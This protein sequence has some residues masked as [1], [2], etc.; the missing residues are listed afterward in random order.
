MIFNQSI[1]TK[2]RMNENI[3]CTVSQNLIDYSI[4]PS[5]LSKLDQLNSD[6]LRQILPFLTRI[7][8]RSVDTDESFEQLKIIIL[9]KL[10]LFEDTNQIKAYLNVDFNQIYE[11][12]IKH[13]ATRKKSQTLSV[14]SCGI[15]F[16]NTKFIYNLKINFIKYRRIRKCKSNFKIVNDIKHSFIWKY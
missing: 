11:D 15:Q 16:F 12:V 14:Y 8:M 2:K 9:E 7:W 10:S 5:D 1:N 6:E 3:A 13:L 4:N